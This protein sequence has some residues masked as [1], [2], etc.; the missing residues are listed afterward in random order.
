M[1]AN[2]NSPKANARLNRIKI[3]SRIV[4]YTVLALFV[5]TI[6]FWLLSIFSSASFWTA[7]DL[8]RALLDVLL[9]TVL[10]F[11]YWNLAKLFRFYECG[12]IFAAKTI[13]CIKTL[14]VLCA[15]NWLLLLVLNL[16]N[17]WFPAPPPPLPPDVKETVV[18]SGF[19]TGFFSFSIG[20]IN[21]GFLL[22]GF[23]IISIAW[24]MDEGRKTRE[25]QEFTV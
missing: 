10:G 19:S 22:A 20:G 21:F 9:I 13:K 14:G 24:I 4:R 25:E 2:G 15:V 3:V 18:K 17:R 23:V 6:G 1:N 16:V 12:L 8:G 11:W 7:K 5:F